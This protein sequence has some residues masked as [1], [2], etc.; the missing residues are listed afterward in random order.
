M[1]LQPLDSGSLEDL[2]KDLSKQALNIVIAAT[3]GS[4]F[5]YSFQKP[6]C[7]PVLSVHRRGRGSWSV[8]DYQSG[9]KCPHHLGFAIVLSAR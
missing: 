5:A 6:G 4:L 1:T 7:N 8:V 2:K 9:G 3:L